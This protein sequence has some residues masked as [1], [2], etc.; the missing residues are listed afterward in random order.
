MRLHLNENTAGCSPAVLDTLRRLGRLDA[1]FYPD[2]DEARTAVAQQFGVRDEQVLL[3]NGLDEGILASVGAAFRDRTGGIPE[4][5]GVE[6]AFDMYEVCTTALGGRMKTV[7][8]NA[9]FD[10]DVDAL[11]SAVTPATRIVFFDQ[12]AQSERT[13]VSAGAVSHAGRAH[14]TGLAVRRRGLRGFLR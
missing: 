13:F 14:R 4:T 1:G 12:S 9:Q 10:L 6:P 3:T 11:A 5:V 8:L 7:R 2:Y